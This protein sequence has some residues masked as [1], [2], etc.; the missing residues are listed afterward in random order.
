MGADSR[1]T[2]LHPRGTSTTCGFSRRFES[3]KRW[4]HNWEVFSTESPGHGM[5]YSM[6]SAD[7]YRITPSGDGPSTDGSTAFSLDPHNDVTEVARALAAHGGGAIAFDLALDLVMNDVVEQA[8]TVTGATGAAIALS[9]D[10]EMVCRATTGPDAPDLGVRVE[11]KTGLSGACLKT[12]EVQ[13]CLDTEK[14]VRVNAEICRHLGVRSMV[15]VP[16]SDGEGPFGILEVFSSKPDAFQERDIEAL[17]ALASRIV[18]NKKEADEGAR[19]PLDSPVV[20]S[21]SPER[22]EEM[23]DPQPSAESEFAPLEEPRSV[24]R[25][26]VWT[27]VLGVLVILVAVTLGVVIGWRRSEQGSKSETPVK[28]EAAP[29]TGSSRAVT[30]AIERTST[31]P[32][33][34]K[35]APAPSSKPTSPNTTAEPPSGGLVVTQNGKVIYR[36]PST[37]AAGADSSE[38]TNRLVHRVEPEYPTE[39]RTQHIQGS[40]VL[41]VQVLG[42]GTVGNI[43]TVTGNPLLADAAVHAVKQWK[44]QPYVVD[45]QPVQSQTRITIKFRLPES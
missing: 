39:A 45:G 31:P 6:R 30:P 18:A 44:Y 26:D 22:I 15:I 40:V 12:G 2:P 9:R 5:K 38:S 32:A 43:E 29:V 36:V 3:A 8:R 28:K 21:E 13:S 33:E 7:P 35:T 41:E 10:G 19:A 23:R 1:K 27:S 14:D 4:P 34:S 24:R 16:L 25:N 17:R 42:D 20:V 37:G 11:T